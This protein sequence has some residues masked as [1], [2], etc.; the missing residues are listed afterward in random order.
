MPKGDIVLIT[1]PFTDLTGSKLRPA[2]I[3]A[4]TTLDSTVCFITTQLQW[5]E[6]TDVQLIPTLS[7]G[8]KKQS[9]IRTS[10]IATLDK[11]L[12]KG[13]LGRLTSDELSDLNDKLKTFL[14][15]K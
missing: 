1:F 15:L 14:R 4:D 11:T 3:L 7:N 6:A 12:A 10:K 2:V 8:L 9:L 5:Q 13:L